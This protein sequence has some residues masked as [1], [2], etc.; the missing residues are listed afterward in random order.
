MNKPKESGVKEDIADLA[1]E[2]QVLS[3]HI[4]EALQYRGDNV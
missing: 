3:A 1:G 2:T 4:A